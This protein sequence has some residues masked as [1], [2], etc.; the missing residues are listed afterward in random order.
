MT[1]Y[2]YEQ[3]MEMKPYLEGRN[4]Y[5]KKDGKLYVVKMNVEGRFILKE[6]E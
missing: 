4:I 3:I 2:T 6:V 1:T 5:V